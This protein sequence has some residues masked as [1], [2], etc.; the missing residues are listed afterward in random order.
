MTQGEERLLG[1]RYRLDRMLGRGGM[2]TVWHAVDEVLGRSVA[3]KEVTTPP[4]LDDAARAVLHERMLREARA[5]ARLTHPGIVTVHDVVEE[6]GVPWIVMEFVQA[7]T[8]QDAIDTE[9]ALPV[10][11]VTEIGR[12]LL[13]ALRAAHNAGILHRDVKPANVMLSEDRAVLTDFG[14]A[15]ME[16]DVSLTQTGIVMGSPAYMSPERAQGVKPGPP[17]DLWALGATLFTALEGY[18]AFERPDVLSTLA[19]V[20]MEP[21]PQLR[22][23]TQLAPLITGLLEKDP[24][25]RLNAA[26]ASELLHRADSEAAAPLLSTTPDR[27]HQE[28]L[29]TAAFEEERPSVGEGFDSLYRPSAAPSRP[30]WQDAPTFHTS[31]ALP[32]V[33]DV[34]PPARPVSYEQP[35]PVSY[36]QQPSPVSYGQPPQASYEPSPARHQ[37]PSTRHMAPPP[38]AHQSHPSHPTHAA[39]RS[40][41]E[42][43]IQNLDT[44]RAPAH[45]PGK[46]GM[47]FSALVGSVAGI[48][49]IIALIFVLK[50]A[51]LF[52][53]FKEVSGEGF[54]LEVPQDW[55]KRVEE[56]STFWNDPDSD[57]YVQ[58]DRTDWTVDGSAYRSLDGLKTFKGFEQVERKKL[59]KIAGEPA[60]Q[61]E[62]LFR[63]KTDEPR[64]GINR[65]LKLEGRP[66]ALFVVY[67][68]DEWPENQEDAL[69]ILDSFG[70]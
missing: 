9:G 23:G 48:L 25:V 1:S 18:S 34:P 5:A 66:W 33:R 59:E 64:H 14:I 47:G 43:W 55:D 32:P 36:E 35:S 4:G 70:P 45:R 21:V 37:T 15:Q 28:F 17:A 20:M 42:Q 16:G 8:L 56:N 3:V 53:E 68:A 51:I 29:P 30:A 54:S 60:A 31:S 67:P 44:G 11:R 41:D 24:D 69:R 62:F 40:S 57:A 12:Q 50:P 2:G 7:S 49:A 6:D 19:A 22:R 26:A 10:A 58:V 46:R 39:Q 63:S 13:G 61:M 27:S 38:P 65:K 52:G